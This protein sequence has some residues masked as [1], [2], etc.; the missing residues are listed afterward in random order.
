MTRLGA[1]A[2]GMS[3]AVICAGVESMSRVPM[4]GFNPSPN[5]DAL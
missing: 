2:M 1:I 5:P 4:G 3:D